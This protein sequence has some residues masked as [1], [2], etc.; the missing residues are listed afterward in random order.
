MK[1][2]FA[3]CAMAVAAI[4]CQKQDAFTPSE[5]VETS[6]SVGSGRRHDLERF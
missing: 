2:I 1:K 3:M 4:A 5:L 6:F